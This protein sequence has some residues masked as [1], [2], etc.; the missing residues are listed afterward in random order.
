LWDDSSLATVIFSIIASSHATVYVAPRQQVLFDGRIIAPRNNRRP[1]M[2]TRTREEEKRKR[3]QRQR[4][5][6]Q[7]QTTSS[8]VIRP[9]SP[10]RPSPYG[11]SNPQCR[12]VGLVASGMRT[13]TGCPW[14]RDTCVAT[15]R[16]W[17]PAL[18][19]GSYEMEE[20][21][22]HSRLVKRRSSVY[23]RTGFSF[24]TCAR[25]S[26]D[27]P[28]RRSPQLFSFIGWWYRPFIREKDRWRGTNPPCVVAD[29]RDARLPVVLGPR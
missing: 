16:K 27:H 2:T 14:N 15:P 26:S 29:G 23:I 24:Y 11:L 3:S 20:W 5:R 7:R 1:Q 28:C 25:R 6:Q 12:T 13:S 17:T 19:I 22:V 8:T 21:L 4:R 9:L 18:L 10:P